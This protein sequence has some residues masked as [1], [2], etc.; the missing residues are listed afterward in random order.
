MDAI[1]V[2]ATGEFI[3][4]IP[5]NGLVTSIDPVGYLQI[6][7]IVATVTG[8]NKR[9]VAAQCLVFYA[10]GFETSSFTISSCLHAAAYHPEIQRKVQ[11]EID[12]VLARHDGLITYESLQ[13]MTYLDSVI[14]GTFIYILLFIY[15]YK[16]KFVISSVDI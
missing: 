16:Y 8:V 10:A 15:D 2:S 3:L 1:T 13:E 7:K 4:I 9:N 11:T 14:A 12:N 6:I 5:L